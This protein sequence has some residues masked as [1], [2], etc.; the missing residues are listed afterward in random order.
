VATGRT[1]WWWVGFNHNRKECQKESMTTELKKVKLIR[2]AAV[3]SSFIFWE[4]KDL[5][6]IKISFC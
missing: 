1:V 3:G 5:L 4:Y 2:S 6:K